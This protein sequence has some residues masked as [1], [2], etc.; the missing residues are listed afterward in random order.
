MKSS[1]STDDGSVI[2]RWHSRHNSECYVYD[3]NVV[4]WGLYEATIWYFY[5]YTEFCPHD[6]KITA[7]SHIQ[8]VYPDVEPGFLIPCL[9]LGVASQS[10]YCSCIYAPAPPRV[11]CWWKVF[12]WQ[13]Q[14]NVLPFL[15]S[16]FLLHHTPRLE[17][18][19][20]WL[21]F[22]RSKSEGQLLKY[23]IHW[24]EFLPWIQ[25]WVFPLF[26]QKKVDV[27]L[28]LN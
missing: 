10:H 11:R 17:Q 9:F 24:A 14:I 1:K 3:K 23:T 28:T 6:P 2:L 26:A 18:T 27:L 20:S 13:L 22:L 19:N 4:I 25:N 5:M 8:T 7:S 15:V 12:V 16:Q 21:S